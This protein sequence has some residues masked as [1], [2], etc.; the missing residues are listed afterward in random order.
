MPQILSLRGPPVRTFR[1]CVRSRACRRGPPA[2]LDHPALESPPRCSQQHPGDSSLRQGRGL[3]RR[4]T[5]SSTRSPRGASFLETWT[6]W[7]SWCS[8]RQRPQVRGD[9]RS[10]HHRRYDRRRDRRDRDL[11]RVRRRARRARRSPSR[12]STATTWPTSP[13]VSGSRSS[14]PPCRTTPRSTRHRA[15]SRPN[16]LAVTAIRCCRRRPRDLLPRR[17][18]SRPPGRPRGWSCAARR[19]R[20]PRPM[21]GGWPPRR[22]G[23]TRRGVGRLRP[24]RRRLHRGLRPRPAVGEHGVLAALPTFAAQVDQADDSRHR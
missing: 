17:S 7:V 9:D 15:G 2:G 4:G 23:R 22:T 20:R 14:T 12:T 5:S 19:H 21:L 24:L 6:A 16:L 13:P 18:W 1:T 8:A 10:R 11:R 3:L